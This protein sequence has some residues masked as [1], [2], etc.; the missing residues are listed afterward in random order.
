MLVALYQ[1]TQAALALP[2]PEYVMDTLV[3]RVVRAGIF[4]R[5]LMALVDTQTR[6]V[7][8]I[9]DVRRLKDDSFGWKNHDVVGLEYALDDRNILSEVA[10]TGEMQIIVGRD[11]RFDRRLEEPEQDTNSVSCFIPVIGNEGVVAVVATDS[12]VDRQEE[13]LRRIEML[14]P[15]LNQVVMNLEYVRL[16]RE[17][18]QSQEQLRALSVHIQAVREE[19]R[20]R[21]ARELHDE[22]GQALTGLKMDLAWLDSRLGEVPDD[23]RCLLLERTTSMKQLIDTTIQTTRRICSEL[24]PGILDNLGLSVAIEWQVQEFQQRTGIRCR[25]T[26]GLKDLEIAAERSTAIFRMFQEILTNVARHANATGVS[27]KLKRQ[28]GSLLLEVRDNGRGITESE[29][30]GGRSLG[31][32]GMREW[33]LL[34]GGNMTIEGK[35]GK[36]TTVVVQIPLNQ[37][38]GI[39]HRYR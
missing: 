2:A 37:T 5:M 27:V 21:I 26:S 15:W 14:R 8:V 7:K 4:R 23:A 31:L 36:G 33:A 32:M 11:D 12:T 24:R 22:L 35:P 38:R 18:R 17:A 20:T 6:T 9:K 39:E 13:M 28:R 30:I 25:L 29:V 19:E 34:L 16:Y 3:E 1:I 10:R